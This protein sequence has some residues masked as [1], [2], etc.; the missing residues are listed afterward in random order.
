MQLSSERL[1]P[2]SQQALWDALNN[3]EVLRACI[4]GCESITLLGPDQYELVMAVKIGPVSAK[5]KGRMSLTDIKPPGS[6]SIVFEGQGGMAGFAKGSADVVLLPQAQTDVTMLQY[7][8]EAQVGG[9]LAQLGS[10]LIDSSAKKMADDFFTRF[11]AVFSP[12]GVAEA[13][14]DPVLPAAGVAGS[15]APQQAGSPGAWARFVG[16]IQSLFHRKSFNHP[17]K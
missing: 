11:V 6:Y 17:T 5:F 15:P 4:P 12:A 13:G 1:V 9:K 3:P 2:A 8:V 16:F 14:V 7:K 10:R